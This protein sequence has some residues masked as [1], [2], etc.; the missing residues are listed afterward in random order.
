MDASVSGPMRFADN[1]AEAEWAQFIRSTRAAAG[2]NA[3]GAGLGSQVASA[4]LFERFQSWPRLHET[5]TED[6]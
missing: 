3:T 5:L 1:N 6:G 4:Y 2:G